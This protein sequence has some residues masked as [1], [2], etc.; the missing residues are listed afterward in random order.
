MNQRNTLDARSLMIRD[1]TAV[2]VIFST[3]MSVYTTDTMLYYIYIV[4]HVVVLSFFHFWNV[5]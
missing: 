2:A 3:C 1:D 4:W 5:L